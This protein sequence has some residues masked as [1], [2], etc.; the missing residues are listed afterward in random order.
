MQPTVVTPAA[1]IRPGRFRAWQV[2]VVLVLAGLAGAAILLQIR[3]WSAVE[4]ES[5]SACAS[6]SAVCP[7]GVVPVLVISFVVGLATIPFVIAAVVR[8]P[9]VNAG[10]AVVGLVAGV[11]AAQALSGGLHAT[12]L[13]VG[14]TAPYD[15]TG[16]PATEGVWT[17]GS[18]LIRVRA[19]QVVSYQ[20]ATG[21]Q[22]WTLAV[23]GGD[24]A[25][26]VSAGTSATVGLIGYG[27][28]GGACD[29]VL[30]VDLGT[31]Q[32]LWSKRVA[33]GWKGDQGTGFAAVGGDTAVAV[34]AGAVLGYDQRT[35]A[36]RWTAL[37]PPG[38]SDQ[39]LAG[40]QQSVVVLAACGKS[41]DVIALAPATGKQLWRTPVPGQAPGYH[42]AIL[43]AD[44]VVVTDV[45]PGQPEQVL[46]FGATG[47]LTST[48]PVGGL[49]T[50]YY[51]GFGPQ[52][53]VSGGL[54]VG[55]TRSGSHADVV[56]YRLSDGGRQWLVSM[57]DD[58]LSLWQ[59]G[60]QLLVIDQSR[61]SLALDAISLPNGSLH[62]I[63]Y[64]P[65]SIVNPSGTS[66]YSAGGRYVV[67]NLSGRAPV[68]PA[69][70]VG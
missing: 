1:A 5:G 17:T 24:V 18:S 43:S 34:T 20:A 41:F 48:I 16:S 21:R 62:T 49:D 13:R 9:K 54:L 69:A 40:A 33:A 19:D 12:G 39:T 64:I 66:V 15:A 25:C 38:C 28:A 26:A 35:G 47:H 50:S 45:A 42:F 52:V 37:T 30:A 56:A 67:V 61:P 59:D 27:T 10:V 23:P 53:A 63:G 22:Q 65:A 55:V 46:A 14:W 7:H 3:G 29:Q 6:G 31:G 4:G 2:A 8:R 51:Q 36:S 60:G 32:Q 68:P 57:P 44:P 11:F 58:V 70:A